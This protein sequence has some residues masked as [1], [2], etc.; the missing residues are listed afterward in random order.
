M[1][2]QAIIFDLDG[3]LIDS[4]QLW[5]QVDIEFLTKRGIAV[6]A[7]LFD[8]IPGGNSF[9]QTAQYFKERFTLKE[10]VESI[11]K[12]WTLMLEDHYQSDVKLKLGVYDLLTD[13]KEAGIKMGLATSNSL[14]LARIVLEANG[15]LSWFSAISTGDMQL[16]GK[17]FADIYLHCA[18]SLKVQPEACLAVEDT[19]AGVQAAKAAGM[20]TFAIFDEDSIAYWEQIKSHA[21]LAFED[22]SLLAKQL[23]KELEKG[24]D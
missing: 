1:Q 13:I 3:T 15:I 24:G 23:W 4:M 7:D 2:Y 5:R 19:L 21:D 6:P 9:I 14:Y 10:S 17:P 22:Y 16:K 11:M 12:D 8:N 20:R 18:S